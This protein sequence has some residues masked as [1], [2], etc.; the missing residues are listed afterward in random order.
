[1][2]T[3]ENYKI[4]QTFTLK[5]IPSLSTCVLGALEFLSNKTLPKIDIPK[6]KKL[7]VLGSGNALITGKII[8][9]DYNAIFADE[10][11]FKNQIKK[12]KYDLAIIISAS[13]SKHAPLIAKYLN[14]KKIKSIL[15]TTNKDAPAKKYVNKTIV[16]PKQ[17]EPYTYNTSTYLSM[18]ISKT[19]ESPS[20]IYKQIKKIKIN[21][22]LKNYNAFFL[23][24]PEKFN[25]AKEMLI[26]KF[27]EL[28]GPMING[29]VYTF[30]QTKHA[31]TLV[32]SEKELFI[33]LGIKNKIFGLK[34][35][36]IPISKDADYGE[37]IATS[38][39]VIGKIQEAHKPYFKE[40]LLNYT[41][42]ISKIFN[43]KIEPI[44]E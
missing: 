31:K 2:K 42:K 28:F 10:S 6:S 44:V 9:K 1:M 43:T 15:L 20:K 32:P 22:N 34:R 3:Q 40:N 38:Y 12:T 14:S 27:D 8:F 39:Y 23:I 26:T 33:S 17:R 41:K 4:M 36:N 5:N 24:L 30:E 7:L 35:I 25:E 16:F 37:F 29:R 18:I 21:Q 19:K 11:S 13:G